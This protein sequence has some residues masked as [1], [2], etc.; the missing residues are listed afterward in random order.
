[1]E[2]TNVR[3]RRELLQRLRVFEVRMAADRGD[4]QARSAAAAVE[5]LIRKHIEA[6]SGQ[7]A[8]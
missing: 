5:D 7:A 1:M 4:E 6:D 2:W 3:V 8:A